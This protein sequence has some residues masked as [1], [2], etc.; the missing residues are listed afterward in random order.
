MAK[1]RPEKLIIKN[2]QT[3]CRCG[4]S[5]PFSRCCEPFLKG[6]AKPSTAEQL[7]RSRFT[8]FSLHDFEYLLDT[9]HPNKRQADELVS[10]QE[11]AQNT[12]WIQLAILQTELGQAGDT[13]GIV[14]FTASFAEDGEFYQLQERSNFIFEQQQ[15]FY[16][17]GSNQVNPINLK[18]GRNDL[19]WCHS[20]KKFK[21]CHG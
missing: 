10:L 1:K 7:M 2:T 16:T 17:E 15:W 5:Q 19:C 8:A 9:L 18:I 14:E 21:K 13:E 3:L 20:G 11:S 12:V 4:S 6:L